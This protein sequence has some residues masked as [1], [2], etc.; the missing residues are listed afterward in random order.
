MET[1]DPHLKN[2]RQ[3]FVVIISYLFDNDDR[4]KPDV[5]ATIR[6]YIADNAKILKKG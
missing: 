1:K 3:D 5:A 4:V 2:M 6:D